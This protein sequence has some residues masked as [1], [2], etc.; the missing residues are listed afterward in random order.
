M[1][2]S[3]VVGT[4]GSDTAAAAVTRAIQM[5]R[6]AGAELHLV[7]AYKPDGGAGWAAMAGASVAVDPRKDAEAILERAAGMVR[8]GGVT[9][10]THAIPGPPAGALIEVARADDADCIV[11]GSRGLRGARRVL[12]S[13]ASGVS[14]HADCDVMIV[15]TC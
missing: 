13:V 12:G 5:A 2:N 3:I 7:S 4:D 9:V 14:H 8:G 1:V 15:R 6:D 10:E 11:V